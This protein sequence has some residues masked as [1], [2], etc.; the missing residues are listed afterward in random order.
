MPSEPMESVAAS[1]RFGCLS[2]AITPEATIGTAGISHKISA[3]GEAASCGVNEIVSCINRSPL[4][5]VHLVEVCSVRMA[6]DGDEHED[7]VAARER[8]GEADGK[9]QGCNEKI[10]CERRHLAPSFSCM[11]TMTAPIVA[12]VSSSATISSGST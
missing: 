4:H 6:M 3:I 1:F 12:A 7:G 9:Q 10:P 2:S 5:P 8:T 11:A